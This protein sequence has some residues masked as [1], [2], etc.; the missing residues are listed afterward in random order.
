MSRDVPLKRVY[1]GAAQTGRRMR[2]LAAYFGLRGRVYNLRRN[3]MDSRAIHSTPENHPSENGSSTRGCLPIEPFRADSRER[4]TFVATVASLRTRTSV[5]RI[6][7]SWTDIWK[8][9]RCVLGV[10]RCWQ[11]YASATVMKLSVSVCRIF[12]AEPDSSEDFSNESNWDWTWNI[13]K[14]ISNIRRIFHA[15]R[16]GEFSRSR[17]RDN[18]NFISLSGCLVDEKFP[19]WIISREMIQVKIILYR[20][21]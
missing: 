3:G 2:I 19:L 9:A 4:F 17:S 20:Y 15:V 8:I 1:T 21:L 11:L 14:M 18:D 6:Q 7:L 10:C 5:A 16:I 12:K 13:F